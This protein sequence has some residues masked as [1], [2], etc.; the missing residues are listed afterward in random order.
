MWPKAWSPW[1]LSWWADHREENQFQHSRQQIPLIGSQEAEHLIVEAETLCL[2]VHK[3]LSISNLQR[4]SPFSWKWNMGLIS[5][6]NG[7]TILISRG[8]IGV[9][10]SSEKG[11]QSPAVSLSLFIARQGFEWIICAD[12]NGTYFE[13]RGNCEYFTIEW[14]SW[15]GIVSFDSRCYADVCLT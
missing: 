6:T 3:L 4:A 10:T 12:H 14:F 5:L 2:A 15:K 7:G 1:S 13:F 8:W 9:S 11:S